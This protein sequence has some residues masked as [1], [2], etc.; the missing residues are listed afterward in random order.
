VIG[1]NAFTSE[2][3][4]ADWLPDSAAK[5][6]TSV[7]L[8]GVVSEIATFLLFIDVITQF[9]IDPVLNDNSAFGAVVVPEIAP[10]PAF[11]VD[12]TT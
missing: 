1:A 12:E 9:V 10:V 5:S 4:V 2:Y 6:H 7:I 3:P 8:A 11:N